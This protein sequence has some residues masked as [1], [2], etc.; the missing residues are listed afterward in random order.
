MPISLTLKSDLPVPSKAMKKFATETLTKSNLKELITGSASQRFKR[1]FSKED[2]NKQEDLIARL[3]DL[4]ARILLQPERRM[5]WFV[6][7]YLTAFDNK[8]SEEAKVVFDTISETESFKKMVGAANVW[9]TNQQRKASTLSSQCASVLNALSTQNKINGVVDLAKK[10]SALLNTA[11]PIAPAAAP[12]ALTKAELSKRLGDIQ[13]SN[14][15]LLANFYQALGFEEGKTPAQDEIVDALK[16]TPTRAAEQ[17]YNLIFQ[18]LTPF[19]ELPKADINE[20]LKSLMLTKK[21]YQAGLI[22]RSEYLASLA[23]TRKTLLEAVG[24]EEK[25]QA[26][27]AAKPPTPPTQE[28]IQKTKAAIVALLTDIH[29]V[30]EPLMTALAGLQQTT[31]DM[32]KAT[33]PVGTLSEQQEKDIKAAI[34]KTLLAEA[35]KMETI[36][37]SLLLL[38]ALVAALTAV[39]GWV[40]KMFNFPAGGG[41]WD[42]PGTVRPPHSPDDLSKALAAL[43]RGAG[44]AFGPDNIEYDGSRKKVGDTAA[45]KAVILQALQTGQAQFTAIVNRALVLQPASSDPSLASDLSL[46]LGIPN[47]N[48]SYGQINLLAKNLDEAITKVPMAEITKIVEVLQKGGI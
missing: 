48:P 11:K 3:D 22:E 13:R 41:Y 5:L 1:L 4:R 8:V 38:G 42:G 30:C 36:N 19:G 18:G 21:L 32:S 25:P 39:F 16:N 46:A 29:N 31:A 12:V 28:Q 33:G 40:K 2:R 15:N 23:E 10:L 6:Q 17:A 34:K 37:E 7:W 47:T 45:S 35:S 20:N 26:A 43:T 9:R 14:P 44:A 27:G 24:G